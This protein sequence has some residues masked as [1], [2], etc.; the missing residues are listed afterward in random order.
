[1][2]KIL[3]GVAAL[4]LLAGCAPFQAVSSPGVIYSSPEAR[5]MNACALLAE[6]V[7]PGINP[8]AVLELGRG[9]IGGGAPLG[10]SPAEALEKCAAMLRMVAEMN[11]PPA[12]ARAFEMTPEETASFVLD[13][14]LPAR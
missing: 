10:A 6:L 8:L 5:A 12:P 11:Q 7:M 1:M 13:G 2:R 14:F 4:A 9:A 3:L